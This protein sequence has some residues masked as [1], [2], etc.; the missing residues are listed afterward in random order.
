M[1]WTTVLP[2]SRNIQAKAN[3]FISNVLEGSKNWVKKSKYSVGLSN[4]KIMI[5]EKYK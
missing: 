1:D 3:V 4:P 2:F 5:K